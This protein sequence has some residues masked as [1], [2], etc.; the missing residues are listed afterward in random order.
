MATGAEAAEAVLGGVER[1]TGVR[2]HA[3]RLWRCRS[4]LTLLV[5]R[6]LWRLSQV[7]SE[8]A[9][10][11]PQAL[12]R[13]R[14]T[15]EQQEELWRLWRA[16]WRVMRLRLWR[17]LWHVDYQVAGRPQLFPVETVCRIEMEA[18]RM[19][20]PLQGATVDTTETRCRQRWSGCP[21]QP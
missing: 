14:Q 5:W 11:S 17:F 19:D 7:G 10:L 6:G 3:A 13:E 21:E 8:L 18:A 16:L 15:P 20:G 2:L 12:H 4:S 1:W 9:H